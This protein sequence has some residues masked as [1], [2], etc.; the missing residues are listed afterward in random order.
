[1]I[2]LL[3]LSITDCSGLLY[4]PTRFLVISYRPLKF[5]PLEESSTIAVRKYTYF[6]LSH[7]TLHSLDCFHV[8]DMCLD[9]LL[10]FLTVIDWCLLFLNDSH[11]INK[12]PL[13]ML[14]ICVTQSFLAYLRN[15]SI[16]FPLFLIV[17]LASLSRTGRA[18]N[19]IEHAELV[20]IS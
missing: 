19:L 13:F 9:F 10:S 17:V 16:R 20:N 7:I 6:C 3:F 2:S 8:F 14:V 4:I 15:S 11:G 18:W 5:H 1:M 12:D